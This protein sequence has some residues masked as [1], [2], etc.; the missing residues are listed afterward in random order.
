MD[1]VRDVCSATSA[2]RKAN[3]LR[4][5]LPLAELTVVTELD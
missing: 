4:N 5:R 3:N 1:Q 2:L